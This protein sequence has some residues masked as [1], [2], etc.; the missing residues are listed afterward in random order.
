MSEAAKE[1]KKRR[2]GYETSFDGLLADDPQPPDP[3]KGVNGDVPTVVDGRARRWRK[4]EL[5][6]YPSAR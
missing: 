5:P 4:D 6:V 2:V 1:A 3:V